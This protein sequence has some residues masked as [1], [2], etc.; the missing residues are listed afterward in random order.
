MSNEAT[1]WAWQVEGL[2][3]VERLLLVALADYADEAWSCFPSQAVLAARACCAE[4]TVR[5]RLRSMEDRGLF[6]RDRRYA[7]GVRTSDRFVLNRGYRQ[8]L[9]VDGYR[10]IGATLPANMG[11]LTGSRL[12]GN[13]QNHQNHQI[14]PISPTADD[15]QSTDF[16]EQ[17]KGAEPA[18]LGVQVV[19]GAFSAFWSCYPKK[20]GKRGAEQAFRAA[21]K[22]VGNPTPILE[23]ARRLRDDPNLPKGVDRKYIP[24]ASTWLNQDR[25]E[26]EPLPARGN[27]GGFAGALA[28]AAE[29]D[30]HFAAMES[31]QQR[32]LD[33]GDAL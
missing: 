2:Q 13:H 25:W 1:N 20:V 14:T 19:D 7:D 30:A 6:R 22:R 17:A 4:R 32:A 26:D 31:A 10:Q 18:V 27:G 9:P 24:H 12:P 11:D 21:V 3:P 29:A 33:A 16:V 28:A 5:D 15:E 8:D 23:G